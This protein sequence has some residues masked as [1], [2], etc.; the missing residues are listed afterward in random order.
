M[1][2]CSHSFSWPLFVPL[3]IYCVLFICS[4][5]VNICSTL[6]PIPDFGIVPLPTVRLC[7]WRHRSQFSHMLTQEWSSGSCGSL[8]FNIFRDYQITFLNG[9]YAHWFVKILHVFLVACYLN[10]IAA[11]LGLWRSSISAAFFVI[12]CDTVHLSKRFPALSA[13]DRRLIFYF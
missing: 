1:Y 5:L 7:L 3:W 10:L 13:R 11:I 8:R 12:L 2:V 4:W 6:N 9:L